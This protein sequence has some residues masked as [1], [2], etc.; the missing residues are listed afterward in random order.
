MEKWGDS[1]HYA[2]TMEH[3][4][5]H[6]V[7]YHTMWSQH[8]P[9]N[10]PTPITPPPPPHTHLSPT[11]T[12]KSRNPATHQTLGQQG[13]T[14]DDGH[15]HLSDRTL[16]VAASRRRSLT[17]RHYQWESKL[18][19]SEEWDTWSD[20]LIWTL[21]CRA[22]IVLRKEGKPLTSNRQLHHGQHKSK[23]LVIRRHR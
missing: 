10:S 11:L 19:G 9:L 16:S 7:Y 4:M 20:T 22:L 6:H 5:Q 17:F 1:M 12:S 15:I 2:A 18:L 8:S 3:T 13:G 23:W 14:G 21:R